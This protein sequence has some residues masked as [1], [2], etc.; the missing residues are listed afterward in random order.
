MIFNLQSPEIPISDHA[1][2][3]ITVD[4][5]SETM[6]CSWNNENFD[7]LTWK[8]LQKKSP[9]SAQAPHESQIVELGHLFLQ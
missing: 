9:T 4:Q 1:L 2:Q 3:L 7:K 6:V 8:I 5:K